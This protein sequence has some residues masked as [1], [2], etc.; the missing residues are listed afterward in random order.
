MLK[1]FRKIYSFLSHNPLKLISIAGLLSLID[2]FFININYNFFYQYSYI[3]N[4]HII[5]PIIDLICVNICLIT[6]FFNNLNFL[7]FIGF[8]LLSIENLINGNEIIGAILIFVIITLLISNGF[9]HSN[10]TLKFTFIFILWVL[11]II[12]ILPHGILRLVTYIKTTL[13]LILIY[14]SC[15]FLIRNNFTP[16][17]A[18]K[19]ALNKNKNY[20]D[21]IHY[22]KLS[23]RQ[24]KCLKILIENPDYKFSNIASILNISESSVK[25]DMKCIYKTFNISSL[26]ELKKILCTTN[27]ML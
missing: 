9:F 7:Y 18:S 25:K 8:C 26:P 23:E 4:A 16:T 11:S 19:T 1:V 10:S 2:I 22:G 5:T 6:L 13:T 14:T 24:K 12:L 3:P 27:I 20:C 17:S 15:Y 21:L